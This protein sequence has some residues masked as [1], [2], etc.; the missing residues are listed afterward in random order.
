MS[1][2]NN[3]VSGNLKATESTIGE[4]NECKAMHVSV[5]RKK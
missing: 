1:L 4:A 3:S 5:D 2:V